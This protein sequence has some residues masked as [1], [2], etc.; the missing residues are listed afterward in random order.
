MAVP[1]FQS[2]MLPLLQILG[3]GREWSNFDI[4]KALEVKLALTEA[5]KQE[6]LPSGKMR[7]FVNRVAWAKTYLKQAS[8]VLGVRRGV[9]RITEDGLKVLAAAPENINIKYLMNFPGF[10]EFRKGKKSD[11][12]VDVSP[13]GQDECFEQKTPEEYIELGIK[14]V[15]ENVRQEILQSLRRCSPYFFEKL[16]VD[17]LLAMGYGGSRQEAG[18]LTAKGS[19]EGI[20]GII[21]EDK[22]GLDIIYVQAKKWDGNVGRP[23]IQKFAGALQGKRATKGIFITT[24]S[25][26]REPFDFVK[27]ISNRIILIDGEKLSEL[28]V[29]YDIGVSVVQVYKLK[30]MDIDYFNEV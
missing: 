15:G 7:V 13:V 29:E 11:S 5:D 22:L 16:V 23:E 21:N 30:K 20:D 26:T 18:K 19:D 12:Q 6:L 28:M 25:F 14:A 27:S 24:S 4:N 1:D 17:V 3:D 2:I 10:D 9:Y 8:L